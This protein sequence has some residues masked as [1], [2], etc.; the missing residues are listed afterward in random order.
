MVGNLIFRLMKF[1]I[2]EIF[3]TFEILKIQ[4]ISFYS[5]SFILKSK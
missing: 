4:N 5:I 3:K 2:L 1:R